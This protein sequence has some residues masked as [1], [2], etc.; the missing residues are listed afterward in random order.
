MWLVCV[1]NNNRLLQQTV[2]K[3]H[4]LTWAQ[5]IS[6]VWEKSGMKKFSL[7]MSH[8]LNLTYKIFTNE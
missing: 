8:D 3:L 4:F 2:D 1:S 7:M 6:I 5:D